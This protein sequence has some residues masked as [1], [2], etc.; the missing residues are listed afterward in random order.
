M[1]PLP[2]SFKIFPTSVIK[3][4]VLSVA[5]N[6]NHGFII[7]LLF[8]QKPL[9]SISKF[10]NLF[11][12]KSSQTSDHFLV[13]TTIALDYANIVSQLNYCNSI[14]SGFPSTPSSLT[15]YLHSAVKIISLYRVRSGYTSAQTF[16]SILI[17]LREKANYLT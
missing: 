15:Q 8:S 4:F 11:Q 6:K 12:N 3:N 1:S 9:P 14:L 10:C 13:F 2:D 7:E 17:S 5:Q 16:Y